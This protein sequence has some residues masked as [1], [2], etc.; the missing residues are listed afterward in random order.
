MTDA[1]RFV[2]PALAR[3][4]EPLCDILN[5]IIRVGGTT[6]MEVPLCHDDFCNWF[7]T[8]NRV[9]LCHT[10]LAG[11]TPAGFQTLTRHDDLPDGWADIA[12][13]TRRSPLVPGLGRALFGAT[14]AAAR[15]RGLVAINATIRAD[16]LP[17]LSYYRRM[18]FVQYDVSRAVP[19]CDG[20][21]VDRLHH[22]FDL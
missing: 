2:R 10:G 21:P 13:F 9:I 20:R 7:I 11:Q 3:D 22:R 18:G 6:A 16:N 19:L 4:A 15:R 17:G 12:S 14:V 8:G 1:A 5:D